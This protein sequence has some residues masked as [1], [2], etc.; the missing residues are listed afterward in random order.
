MKEENFTS[1]REIEEATLI[2]KRAIKRHVGFGY[3]HSRD[4]IIRLLVNSRFDIVDVTDE[5]IALCVSDAPEDIVVLKGWLF[6]SHFR[7]SRSAYS[8]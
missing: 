6:S 1:Q 3:I 7:L 4:D 8:P 5:S 2:I